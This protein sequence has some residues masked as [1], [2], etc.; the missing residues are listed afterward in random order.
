MPVSWSHL[1]L[2]GMKPHPYNIFH[3]WSFSLEFSLTNYGLL[4]RHPVKM[5]IVLVEVY[6]DQ[7]SHQS[8][9]N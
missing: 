6:T 8:K 5:Q 3:I 4:L 7:N 9:N 1:L 2:L